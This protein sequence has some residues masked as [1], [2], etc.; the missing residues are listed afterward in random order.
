MASA[1]MNPQG[2]RRLSKALPWRLSGSD[3]AETRTLPWRQG[4]AGSGIATVRNLVDLLSSALMIVLLSVLTRGS[5]GEPLPD[6]PIGSELRQ[7]SA[8]AVI[9]PG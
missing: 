1:T 3:W 2:M 5:S 9:A 6:T 7:R 4:A 8:M